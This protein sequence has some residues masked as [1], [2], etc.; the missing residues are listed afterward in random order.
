MYDPHCVY[1][2]SH[3]VTISVLVRPESGTE[4]YSMS[5]H[6]MDAS[7]DVRSQRTTRVFQICN[8]LEDQSAKLTNCSLDPTKESH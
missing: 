2:S 8:F 5:M 1:R 6:L 4:T 3:S 7:Y